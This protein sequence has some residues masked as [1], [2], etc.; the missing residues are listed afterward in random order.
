MLASSSTKPK[1]ETLQNRRRQQT[2]SRKNSSVTLRSAM[3]ICRVPKSIC[4]LGG[5]CVAAI[6]TRMLWTMR[7]VKR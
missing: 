5:R 7:E 4:N 3:K 1:G 2:E 6:V